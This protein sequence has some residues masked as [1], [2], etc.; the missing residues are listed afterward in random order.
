MTIDRGVKNVIKML[1]STTKLA[2]STYDFSI[3]GG[4]ESTYL[5]FL[6]HWLYRCRVFE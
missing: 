1:I 3:V 6:L 5:I 4:I 2:V